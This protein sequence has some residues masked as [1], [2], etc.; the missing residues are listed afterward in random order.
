[1]SDLT[2]E[3]A[4]AFLRSRG[5]ARAEAALRTDLANVEGA[6]Q[7]TLGQSDDIAQF[8][9]KNAPG[10]VREAAQLQSFRDR[11]DPGDAIRAYEGLR[12]FCYGSLDLY[13]EE[14]LPVLLPVFVHL[15][16]QLVNAGWLD[17]ADQLFEVFQRDAESRHRPLLSK[18]AALRSKDVIEEDEMAQRWLKAKYRLRMSQR[19]YGLFIGWLEASGSTYAPAGENEGRGRD[20]ILRIVNQSLAINSA[21][22]AYL[23]LS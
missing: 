6:G 1:M 21:F 8:G 13:R 22:E 9:S 15:Y 2:E 4:L 16:L 11:T 5:Y 20:R 17:I 3:A 14:I 10:R 12:E 19:G 23:V 18:L 7:L